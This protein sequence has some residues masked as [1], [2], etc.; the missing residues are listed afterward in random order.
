MF[1]DSYLN[2]N[3][4]THILWHRYL[5]LTLSP[6]WVLKLLTTT[7]SLTICQCWPS[8]CI[9]ISSLKATFSFINLQNRDLY[10]ILQAFDNKQYLV[11]SLISVTVLLHIHIECLFIYKT[12]SIRLHAIFNIQSSRQ[13]NHAHFLT[14]VGHVR[15]RAWVVVSLWAW[16]DCSVYLIWGGSSSG[17]VCVCVGPL[18]QCPAMRTL[19]ISALF[20]P[21]S[22]APWRHWRYHPGCFSDGALALIIPLYSTPDTC[23]HDTGSNDITEIAVPSISMF[24][25]KMCWNNEQTVNGIL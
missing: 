21:L 14:A 1:T 4:T 6:P 19:L 25:N 11:F 24:K 10:E 12:Y 9:C 23:L 16:H 5:K 7:V 15:R 20:H 22:F 13:H 3:H 8:V 17:C 18:L 2:Y